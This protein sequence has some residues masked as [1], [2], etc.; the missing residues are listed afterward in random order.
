MEFEDLKNQYWQI[1]PQVSKIALL[2][3]FDLL[4]TEQSKLFRVG[5]K[6]ERDKTYFSLDTV[7]SS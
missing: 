7:I 5:I 3:L 1:G 4:S 6:T 2:E